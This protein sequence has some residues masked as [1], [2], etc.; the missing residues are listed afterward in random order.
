MFNSYRLVPD[1]EEIWLR[2]EEA[3][4]ASFEEGAPAYEPEQL[5][6]LQT[7]RLTHAQSD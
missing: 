5:Y 2:N 7:V 6:A 4:I 3:F 1:F